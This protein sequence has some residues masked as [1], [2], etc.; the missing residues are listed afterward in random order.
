M[1]LRTVL[2]WLRLQNGLRCDEKRAPC[3]RSSVPPQVGSLHNPETTLAGPELFSLKWKVATGPI[4]TLDAKVVGASRLADFPY[5]AS[6]RRPSSKD[7]GRSLDIASY[8]I[9]ISGTRW[10]NTFGVQK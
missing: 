2:N 6:P 1:S 5:K 4:V 9:L 8:C 3:V 10:R 7:S